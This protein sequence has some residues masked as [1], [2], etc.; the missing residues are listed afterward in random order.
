M[1]ECASGSTVAAVEV[2]GGEVVLEGPPLLPWGKL[3]GIG[4]EAAWSGID[5]LRLWLKDDVGEVRWSVAC[6]VVDN[7]PYV[8]E[9]D[10]KILR[11]TLAQSHLGGGNYVTPGQ[12]S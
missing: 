7:I 11:W 4:W 12:S 1:V 5:G 10:A 9:A 2:Q 6:S 8:S 3:T